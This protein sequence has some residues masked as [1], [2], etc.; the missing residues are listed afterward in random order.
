MAQKHFLLIWSKIQKIIE[1]DQ[2]RKILPDQIKN[3]V[4]GMIEKNPFLLTLK[5]MSNLSM[6]LFNFYEKKNSG[7]K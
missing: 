7:I 3:S 1:G 2:E 6:E 4:I 5:S